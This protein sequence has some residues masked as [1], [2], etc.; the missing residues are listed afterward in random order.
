MCGCPLRPPKSSAP[1]RSRSTPACEPRVRLDLELSAEAVAR[2]SDLLEGV[3]ADL[4][5]HA[6]IEATWPVHRLL[7]GLAAAAPAA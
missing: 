6:G 3:A 2:L 7:D 4:G 5:H 1:W